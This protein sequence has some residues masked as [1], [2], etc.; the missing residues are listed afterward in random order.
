MTVR[1]RCSIRSTQLVSLSEEVDAINDKLTF[2]AP[3]F[4]SAGI[5]A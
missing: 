2:I 5:T 3:S 1:S 4:T